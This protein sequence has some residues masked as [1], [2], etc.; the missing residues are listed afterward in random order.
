MASTDLIPIITTIILAIVA[1]YGAVLSTINFIKER[2]REKPQ[3]D[4]IFET[5]FDEY[6]GEINNYIIARNNGIKPVTLDCAFIEEFIEPKRPWSKWIGRNER[7]R[8]PRKT[9]RHFIGTPNKLSSGECCKVD[10]N[11][12]ELDVTFG[13][14]PDLKLIAVFVDQLGKRYQSKPFLLGKF[15]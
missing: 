15:L 9:I 12:L 10:I 3:I 7:E 8:D 6:A 14:S 1:I 4:V 2:K 11:Y 5:D 13:Q